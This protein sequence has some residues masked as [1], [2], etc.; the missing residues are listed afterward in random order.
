MTYYHAPRKAFCS[1][2]DVI[3]LFSKDSNV[4][5]PE[6][7]AIY[8]FGMSKMTVVNETKEAKKYDRIELCEMCEMICRVAEN[9]FKTTGIGND[10]M[11]EQILD[12]LFSLTGF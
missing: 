12:E 10:Q 8:C 2:R 9:K 6:K 1:R 11:V 4:M 5:L 3:A 7:V